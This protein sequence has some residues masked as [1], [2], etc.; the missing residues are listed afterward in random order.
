M[1][2]PVLVADP[3]DTTRQVLSAMLQEVGHPVLAVASGAS[4]LAMLRETQPCLAVLEVQLGDDVCG[5]E[6][7]RVIRAQSADTPV[8]FIS[9]TRTEPCDRVAGL[10]VGG[11]DYVVKPFARDELLTRIRKLLGRSRPLPARVNGVLTRRERE[12]LTLLASGMRQDEIAERLVISKKTV[13]TH[14]SNLCRK[15]DVHSQAQAIVVA[16]HDALLEPI[17]EVPS[18]RVLA[19]GG[20]T[21]NI[22][23]PPVDVDAAVPSIARGRLPLP[24]RAATFSPD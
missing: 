8:V 9:G 6:V 7:C 3:D 21:A 23:A 18:P 17:D 13:G 15:L 4:A 16:F 1:G 12:V 20:V 14:V 22:A 24:R 19:L 2:Y 11:D 10:M 5:Y